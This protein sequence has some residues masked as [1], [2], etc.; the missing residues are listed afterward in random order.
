M[1]RTGWVVGPALVTCAI[2]AVLFARFLVEAR[3]LVAAVPSPRPVFQIDLVDVPPGERLCISGVTIPADARQLRFQVGTFGRPGPALDVTLRG[4][5][6]SERLT[7]PAGYPDSALIVAAMEPPAA[8][9]LGEV[10][11]GHR[12]S[13][14]VALVGAEEERTLSRPEGRVGEQ[15]VEADTYLAFYTGGS[16]SALDRAGEIVER[17]SAFRPAVVGPWL[18]WPLLGLVVVGVPAGVL[19]AVLRGVR[20]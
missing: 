2:A 6:Y 9:R 15:R 19:W 16:A 5:S 11:L 10:C 3:E 18:L 7:V 8:P 17:M 14:K 1:S 12:G 20:P 13:T 4:E